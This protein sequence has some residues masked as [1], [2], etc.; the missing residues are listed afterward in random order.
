M[1]IT[2]NC[3]CKCDM[4]DCNMDMTIREFMEKMGI[5]PIAAEKFFKDCCKDCCKEE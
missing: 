2:K 5:D 1:K 3:E 4:S